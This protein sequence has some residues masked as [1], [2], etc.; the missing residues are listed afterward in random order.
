MQAPRPP[1]IETRQQVTRRRFRNRHQRRTEEK[2]S[3]KA[4]GGGGGGGAATA[5]A[6]RTFSNKT[7]QGKHGVIP[8]MDPMHE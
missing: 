4:R 1:V 7:L 3:R 8:I 6:L 2:R 5:M